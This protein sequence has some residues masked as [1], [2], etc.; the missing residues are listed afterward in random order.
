MTLLSQDNPYYEFSQIDD[1]INVKKYKDK[2]TTFYVVKGKLEFDIDDK[3]V[4][5]NS[6][7][8][9]LVSSNMYNQ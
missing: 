1:I 2:V 3:K 5:I 9:L 4:E 8:G 7:E 6:T